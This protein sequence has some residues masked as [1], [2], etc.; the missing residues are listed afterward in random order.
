MLDTLR[1]TDREAYLATL[2]LAAEFREDVATLWAF[3][4]EIERI[5]GLVSEPV[6]GEIRLQWWRDVLTGERAGEGAQHPLA[7]ALLAVIE[8][9][10]LQAAAF[11]NL[12]EARIFDLYND[13]MPDQATLEGYLGETR[14]VLF[15]MSLQILMGEEPE[16]GDAAGHAGVAFGIAQILRQ[17]AVHRSQGQIFVPKEILQATGLDAAQFLAVADP[18]ELDPA[19]DALSALGR[20][21]LMK[22]NEAISSLEKSHRTAFLPLAV[23]KLVFERANKSAG[24]VAIEPLQISQLSLQWQMFLRSLKG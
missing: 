22:A 6:P 4:A 9:Y 10:Q 24:L 7:K 5:R 15:Q 17:M 8:K 20:E 11:D 2:F 14:S 12:L 18:A 13:P 1:N 21:H 16:N 19:I 23:C 3:N